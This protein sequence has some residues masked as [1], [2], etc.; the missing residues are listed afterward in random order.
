MQQTQL[1]IL[2]GCLSIVLIGLNAWAVTRGR[3]FQED[4]NL[5]GLQFENNALAFV[6]SI[7]GTYYTGTPIDTFVFP[8]TPFI[9]TH[10]ANNGRFPVPDMPDLV[11][12]DGVVA[13]FVDNQQYVGRCMRM[14]LGTGI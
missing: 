12:V 2:L 7:L 5:P 1:N 6:E 9:F 4:L 3:V 8:A 11:Y 14:E 10:T 13:A